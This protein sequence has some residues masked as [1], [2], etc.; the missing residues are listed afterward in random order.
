MTKQAR[1]MIDS[2]VSTG[3]R[4]MYDKY[5]TNEE[6]MLIYETEKYL[7]LTPKDWHDYY[8]KPREIKRNLPEWF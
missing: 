6:T 4:V 8:N 3:Y 7:I 2:F 1:Q 5:Y